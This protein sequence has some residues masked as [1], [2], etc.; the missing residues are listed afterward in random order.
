MKIES[1]AC[2]FSGRRNHNED[3]FCDE[4]GLGLFA[5]ADGVG[6]YE[7]GEV[8]SAIV[9]AELAA[10]FTR[11]VD[12]PASTWPFRTEPNRSLPENALAVAVQQAHRGIEARREGKLASMASTVAALSVGSGAAVIAHCGDSRVYR[13]RADVLTQ[14]TRDHSLYQQ[15]L[16]SGAADLPPPNEYPFKNVVTRVLGTEQHEAEVRTEPL[17][18]GDVFLLCSDGLVEGAPDPLIAELLASERPRGSCSRLVREA[19]D[20]GS[21]DNITALVVSVQ[22]SA[23]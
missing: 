1:A 9:V 19:Y 5:V 10:F 18:D 21:R 11:Y 15:L 2:S 8:A 13:L 20:R 22:S 16:A 7:G 23:S 17:C 14:L 12:D 6:G 4:P 3:S